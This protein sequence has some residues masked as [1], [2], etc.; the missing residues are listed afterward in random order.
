MSGYDSSVPNSV[1]LNNELRQLR[2][3]SQEVNRRA[4]GASKWASR[5]RYGTIEPYYTQGKARMLF[6]GE[7]ALS[8]PASS[9]SDYQPIP[10]QRVAAIRDET[11]GYLIIGPY[12]ED[13]DFPYFHALTYQNGWRDYDG[14]YFP[15]SV[16]R[17]ASG[18]TK[19][20]GLIAGG[21][22]VS[23]STIAILPETFRP[24]KLVVFP[25]PT[26]GG[27]ARVGIYPD[28]RIT[29]YGSLGW[30]GWVSMDHVWWISGRTPVWV[31]G[32]LQGTWT[33]TDPLQ[34]T[35]GVT[36]LGNGIVL[37]RGAVGNGAQINGGNLMN[38]PYVQSRGQHIM[39]VA[40][41]SHAGI[42]IGWDN[43]VS[44]PNFAMINNKNPQPPAPTTNLELTPMV[45]FNE[46]NSPLTWNT[47]S[48]INGWG[49]V[50][51]TRFYG[52]SYTKTADGIVILR[53]LVG[54]GAV[55]VIFTLPP[56]FRPRRRILRNNI[57]NDTA[58]RID[59]SPIGDVI[60]SS[61]S[62]AW[63]SLDAVMFVAE[64]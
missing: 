50:D 48:L 37:A 25:M 44:K 14:T 57:S 54:G 58:G 7:V 36:D 16:T 41:G 30:N 47:A 5:I 59:V 31:D 29:I 51:N 28:G 19:L 8:D 64:Q 38:Q 45:I 39:S 53:G 6:D 62:N 22:M 42:S 2:E 27:M 33:V 35:P 56:G 43:T 49:N 12:R 3:A 61:G 32:T 63:T 34:G 24:E 21:T 23:G 52:A 20:M 9:M 17:T 11:G 55:G 60:F 10:G 26:N 4:L 1:W 46:V 18:F 15:L 40:N 13:R